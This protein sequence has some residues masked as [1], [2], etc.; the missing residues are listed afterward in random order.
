MTVSPCRYILRVKG[1]SNYH[2]YYEMI[3][4]FVVSAPADVD[5]DIKEVTGTRT[6]LTSPFYAS[7]QLYGNLNAHWLLQ[8]DPYHIMTIQVT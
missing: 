5:D 6:M 7:A 4:I 1:P 2:H 8:T 3:H